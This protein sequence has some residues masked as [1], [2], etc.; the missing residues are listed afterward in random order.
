MKRTDHCP[1]VL[2]PHQA[3]DGAMVRVRLPG[4]QTT[5]P[6]LARLGSVARRHGSGL[7]QLTSRASVQLRG[8]PAQVPDAVADE[9]AG[10]G[11]L[12]SRSH[13]RVRN[14]V[15]SPLT[16]LCP[17]PESAGRGIDLRPMIADLDDAVLAQPEL[18]ALPGRFLF[19]LDDGRGDVTGLTAD[20]TYQAQ[21]QAS[22]LVLVGGTDRGFAVAADRAVPALI[23]IA[24]RFLR[25][26][27]GSGA[28]HVREIPGF[29]SQYRRVRPSPDP[30]CRADR[31]SRSARS[32]GMRASRRRWACS[33]RPRSTW[34]PSWPASARWWSPRG[35]GWWWPGPPI[36]WTR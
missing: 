30:R 29:A 19:A 18:A 1:G 15:A 2:R 25:A 14:I 17:A 11:F 22:G 27:G 12:P 3:A 4:G 33:T 20:L 28:W 5:G 35:G 26:R 16:G 6:G 8:L 23:E 9:L 13:E 21:D 31:A 32:A 10:A 24:L 7:L 36:G 34:W